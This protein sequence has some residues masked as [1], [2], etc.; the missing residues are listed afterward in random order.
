L[1]HAPSLKVKEPQINLHR[2]KRFEVN[3]IP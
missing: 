1:F 2:T 3:G